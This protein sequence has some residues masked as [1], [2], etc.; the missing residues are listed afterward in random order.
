MFAPTIPVPPNMTATLPAM[1]FTSCADREGRFY[2]GLGA[3]PA[4]RI[5]HG[6]SPL[7]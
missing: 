5:R 1:A 4:P 7:M 6:S 2:R 3:M